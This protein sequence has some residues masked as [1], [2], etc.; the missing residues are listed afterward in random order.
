MSV[1]A[2]DTTTDANSNLVAL[3]PVVPGWN[4]V[5]GTPAT[6][7]SEDASATV[8]NETAYDALDAGVKAGKGDAA[9]LAAATV[10]ANENKY[11]FVTGD[12]AYKIVE[13]A[14]AVSATDNTEK[15]KVGEALLVAPADEHGYRVEVTYTRT[16]KVNSTTV[17]PL[18]DTAVV[19]VVRNAVVAGVKTPVPFEA[20]KSYNVVV[21]LY[22]DG[23]ATSDTKLEGW[24]NGDGLEDEYDA[25]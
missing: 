13:D 7:K 9:A 12:K 8:A 16:K 14:A 20:G 15:T 10:A 4:G 23:E 24:E 25:E 19:D 2:Y 22:S 5:A 11:F 21:T 18:S 17:Q 1:P 6:Y 3:V